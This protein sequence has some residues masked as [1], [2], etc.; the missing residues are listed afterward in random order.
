MHDPDNPIE[1]DDPEPVPEQPSPESI[2]LKR[3]WRDGKY[4]SKKIVKNLGEYAIPNKDR[5][6]HCAG[7]EFMKK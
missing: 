4:D 5:H 7:E 2:R 6:I 3:A 1:I